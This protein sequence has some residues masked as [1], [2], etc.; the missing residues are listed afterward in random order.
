MR[1]TFRSAAALSARASAARARAFHPVSEALSSGTRANEADGAGE[2]GLRSIQRHHKTKQTT[3]ATFN[4]VSSQPFSESLAAAATSALASAAPA[5]TTLAAKAAR[6]GRKTART[7]LPN[8]VKMPSGIA[9]R[10]LPGKQEP[11][12]HGRAQLA[13]ETPRAT[14]VTTA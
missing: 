5:S 3:A 11:P 10:A 7:T 9:L 2:T 1:R 14:T 13:R 4:A 12:D 8:A 6:A